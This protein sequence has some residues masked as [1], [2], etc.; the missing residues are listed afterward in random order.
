MHNPR[1]GRAHSRQIGAVN[2]KGV[3]QGMAGVT[4]G[5][6]NRKSGWLIHHQEVAVL[7]NDAQRDALGNGG[8]WRGRHYNSDPVPYIELQATLRW[9]VIDSDMPLSYEPLGMGTG[10]LGGL[11]GG[12]LIQ[13]NP[14]PGDGELKLGAH[15]GAEGSVP[16]LAEKTTK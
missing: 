13:S 8:G 7:I 14:W 5:R 6:M 10:K 16:L 11:L 2:Q 1:S 3:H 4:G 15:F 12:I 9:M